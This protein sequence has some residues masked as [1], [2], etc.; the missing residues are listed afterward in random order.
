[1]S[2][3]RVEALVAFAKSLGITEAKLLHPDRIVVDERFRAYCQ[4]PR[5]PNYGASINCPPHSISPSEFRARISGF[6]LVLAFKFDMPAEALQGEDRREAALLLHQ[7]TAAIEHE[8]KALGFDRASGYSS[9]GCKNSLCHE[10]SNCAVLQEGGACRHPDVARPSLSGM[11][12]DWHALSKHLG[13]L[14]HKSEDGVVNADAQTIMMAGLVF[15][16]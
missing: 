3:E 4:E 2:D 1:M 7:A 10:H 5:C 13:W 11:G 15:L 16:E 6:R 14:M 12:V 9:G 8:A